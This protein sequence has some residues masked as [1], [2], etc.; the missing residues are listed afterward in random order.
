MGEL[1]DLFD[2]YDYDPS[3]SEDHGVRSATCRFC[4]ARDLG[5]HNTGVRW[6]LLGWDGRL[7]DCK[8]T[9]SADDFEDLS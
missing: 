3:D 6:R 4:G 8:S 9:P 5:W 1:A 2:S 7:H